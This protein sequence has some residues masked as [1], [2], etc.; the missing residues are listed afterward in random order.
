MAAHPSAGG[1]G[2]AWH[3][4]S[5]AAEAPEGASRALLRQRAGEPGKA[6]VVAIAHVHVAVV[7]LLVLVGD[8]E[9]AQPPREQARAEMKVELVAA[10]TVEVEQSQRAERLL[11]RVEHAIRVEGEPPLPHAGTER[12]GL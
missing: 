8:A 4:V 10:A 9:L 5:R 12:A 11:M 6:G 1:Q 2:G 7:E 3:D